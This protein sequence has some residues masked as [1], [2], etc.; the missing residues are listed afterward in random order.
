MCASRTFCTTSLE[1]ERRR[2]EHNEGMNTAQTGINTI[3]DLKRGGRAG[4]AARY[5]KIRKAYYFTDFSPLKRVERP[6][7]PAT[8]F[9]G[10]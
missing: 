5:G 8:F 7:T 4:N 10:Q 2:R 9:E 3:L 6:Q 1:S